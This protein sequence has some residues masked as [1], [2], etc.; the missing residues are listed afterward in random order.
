MT[1]DQC[2]V[3]I[4]Q[5]HKSILFLILSNLQVA[6]LSTPACSDEITISKIISQSDISNFL[7]LHVGKM[8]ELDSDHASKLSTSIESLGLCDSNSLKLVTVN[9]EDLV[10]KAIRLLGKHF[11]CVYYTK[12]RGYMLIIIYVCSR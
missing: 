11:C 12:Y 6:I 9:S 7:A 1:R 8:C 2:N 5:K 4:H 3:Y 10:I